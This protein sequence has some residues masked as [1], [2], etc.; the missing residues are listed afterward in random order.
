MSQTPDAEYEH[1]NAT[2]AGDDYFYGHEPGPVARRAVRYHRALQTEGGRALDVGCGEGQDLAF[3]AQSG[4]NGSGL[5]LTQNGVEKARRFLQMRDLKSARVW[6]RD[7]QNENW[8]R[9]LGTFEVVLAINCLQFLGEAAPK[10][11]RQTLDLIAPNGVVGLSVFAREA[12]EPLEDNAELWLPTRD[13]LMGFLPRE[14]WQP[15]EVAQLWQWGMPKADEV[16]RPRMFVTVV[17]RRALN[18]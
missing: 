11:L 2:F 12:D 4:Y 10:S 13:E 18:L 5:E 15:L 14:K 1:W 6:Q 9:D 7:L 17:A 8:P 3:L 16:A